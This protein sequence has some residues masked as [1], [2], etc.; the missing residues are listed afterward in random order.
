M[1]QKLF[2]SWQT[3]T[4]RLTGRNFLE[5]ALEDVLKILHEDATVESAIR[6]EGL[7]LDSDTRG[8]PGTPPVMEAI[9]KKIDEAAVV[10]ADLTFVGKRIDGRPTPNPNVLIEYGCALKSLGYQLIICIM[11]TQYG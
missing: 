2:F 1:T 4:P 11:N 10:V 5:R 7:E 8:V 3:D 6:E 9:Y